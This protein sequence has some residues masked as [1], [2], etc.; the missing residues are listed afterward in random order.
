MTTEPKP[1][2]DAEAPL[3]PELER[4]LSDPAQKTEEVAGEQERARRAAESPTEP[5]ASTEQQP[6]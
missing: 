1:A 2:P 6:T 5:G 4:H 3:S